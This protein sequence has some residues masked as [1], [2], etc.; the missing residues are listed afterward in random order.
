MKQARKLLSVE[1]ALE[2]MLEGINPLPSTSIPL[3]QARGRGLVRE[4]TR[5][6]KPPGL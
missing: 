2:Q 6:Q 4:R 5:A 1:D 3:V